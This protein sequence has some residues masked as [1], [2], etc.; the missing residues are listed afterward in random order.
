MDI[1]NVLKSHGIGKGTAFHPLKENRI[2]SEQYNVKSDGGTRFCTMN[3]KYKIYVNYRTL[4][5]YDIKSNLITTY[6]LG[7]PPGNPANVAID[8]NDIVFIFE[9][10]GGDYEKFE[11]TFNITTAS[12][13]T[14]KQ[15]VGYD[16]Y[17]HV[18][19]YDGYF[20]GIGGVRFAKWEKDGNRVVYI[21]NLPYP[22][23]SSMNF[24]C[25]EGDKLYVR[26]NG[27]SVGIIDAN[28]GQK[29]H[30]RSN[31]GEQYSAGLT[32]NYLFVASRDNIYKLDKNNLNQ[33]S[34][35][36]R[37]SITEN[38]SRINNMWGIITCDNK[39]FVSY[40]STSNGYCHVNMLDENFNILQEDVGYVMINL[41]RCILKDRIVFQQNT[42][43]KMISI[44]I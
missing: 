44:L 34:S 35:V 18:V 3:K 30:D 7:Y 23:S 10:G 22:L 41:A 16:S 26:T 13:V 31:L 2:V 25:F 5:I 12:K 20:Y 32:E 17:N 39:L 27:S 11:T 4:Y 21:D 19:F 24:L 1:N 6:S 15:R 14:R 33:L 29:L 9:N 37:T 36:Y 42:V 43:D 38:S 8:D 40:E 28:T